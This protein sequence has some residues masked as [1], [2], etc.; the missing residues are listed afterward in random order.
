VNLLLEGDDL[1]ALLLR[2]SQ[3]G[4]TSARIVRA[5]KVRRGGLLGFFAKEG[6]E[7][8]VEIPDRIETEDAEEP[9]DDDPAFDDLVLEQRPEPVPAPVQPAGPVKPAGVVRP[10]G[11]KTASRPARNATSAKA[12]KPA[13]KPARLPPRPAPRIE[14]ERM[15]RARLADLI[16]LSQLDEDEWDDDLDDLED[17]LD[18]DDNL[19]L[20]LVAAETGPAPVRSAAT[21]LL[22]LVERTSA[23]ERAAALA[24]ARQAAFDATMRDRSGFV[25]EPEDDVEVLIAAGRPAVAEPQPV[26]RE[27]TP[28]TWPQIRSSHQ[29]GPDG[30][31][32]ASDA[33]IW[34][35]TDP[36]RT[37]FHMVPKTPAAEPPKAPSLIDQ[38]GGRLGRHRTGVPVIAAG[39]GPDDQRVPGA[40]PGAKRARPAGSGA[41]ASSNTSASPGTSA[42]QGISAPSSTA[43]SSGASAPS[44]SSAS[45]SPSTSQSEA[46]VEPD[47]PGRPDDGEPAER[48]S[49]NALLEELAAASEDQDEPAQLIAAALAQSVAKPVLD[50][51]D[52][53]FVAPA[54]P[55]EVKL[56]AT[57]GMYAPEFGGVR[58]TTVVPRHKPR[59]GGVNRAQSIPRQAS[60][61]DSD[62]AEPVEEPILPPE[63]AASVPVQR[64]GGQHAEVL[65][66]PRQS[67]AEPDD[68]EWD[69][70]PAIEPAVPVEVRRT[71]SEAAWRLLRGWRQGNRRRALAESAES[72]ELLRE[73]EQWTADDVESPLDPD[74]ELQFVPGFGPALDPGLGPGLEPIGAELPFADAAINGAVPAGRTVIGSDDQLAA[75]REALELLGVPAAWTEQLAAGDRFTAIVDM[76]G[77][78]IEPTIPDDAAVIAVV[79][80]ADVVELEAHRTALDLPAKGRPRA[81]TLV[82]GQTGVDRRAAI[83]RSKRIRPVVISIPIDGYDDPAGTRRILD[84]VKA[85][86][87]IAVVDAGRPMAEITRWIEALG[88]V[89]AIALDGALDAL[90]PAAALSLHVPVIRVDGISVD[91]IGWAALLCAQL[92][93][94][95]SAQGSA[96]G[97]AEARAR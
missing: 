49:W 68:L 42:P 58:A 54:P 71:S 76:L 34:F 3:E 50:R 47:G 7:V 78:L 46:T 90:T 57:G 18:R 8:A 44:G 22:D 84:S 86:A 88:P 6:F 92:S 64:P 39:P 73:S 74:P 83:A 17:D 97:S 79:G 25:V 77:Q 81:V 91:R 35:N 14:P 13:A 80:P 93:A 1:E 29:P 61:Q 28:L 20:D 65:I 10:A 9:F 5:A 60:D 27:W 32:P 31:R 69:A 24:V 56:I 52:E 70:E 95:V 41:V 12:S 85:E 33:G 75:D 37:S 21:S 96:V 19:E 53:Q 89:D 38:L 62:P 30:G 87:V 51:P 43:E 4:G 82:P 36:A 48:G 72:A 63:P 26:Q 94:G 11:K 45:K 2:A 55:A 40:S 66:D 15:N 67:Y 16:D 23:A 59:R